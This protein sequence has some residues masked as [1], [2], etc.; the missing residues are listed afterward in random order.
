MKRKLTLLC[1]MALMLQM[2][3][4]FP[5]P[6]SAFA[7]AITVTGTFQYRQNF[8]PNTIGETVGERIK[9]GAESVIPNGAQG[10]TGTATQGGITG[11]LTF[12][13]GG[14]VPGGFVPAMP[15]RCHRGSTIASLTGPSWLLT[16]TNG[17]DTN[18]VFT[19]N[20]TDAPFVPLVQD[21]AISGNPL[22]P[23]FTWTIPNG[24]SP[25]TVL[26]GITDRSIPDPTSA[27]VYATVLTGNLTSFTVPAVFPGGGSLTPGHAYSFE[28]AMVVTR[29]HVAMPTWYE[30]SVFSISHT[31]LDFS[32]PLSA[33][34]VP[35]VYD[36]FD[37]GTTIDP[38]KWTSTGTP[39]LF[40]QHDGRLYFSSSTVSTSQVLVSNPISGD[41]RARV[42]FYD[43]TSSSTFL[44]RLCRKSIWR[45]SRYRAG[46]EPGNH[47]TGI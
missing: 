44:R 15:N 23:T 29:G 20:L 13:T 40:S 18:A 36:D 24:F 17:A 12:S 5:S 43:F 37:T 26:V 28:V 9:V 45:D 41:F 30:S 31:Y 47:H 46:F 32:I 39:G 22:T 10:T 11:P 21:L 38:S 33:G 7:A 34:P 27:P 1:V 6:P 4:F 42:D 19:P 2:V 16:F 35:V 14:A 3:P 8:G 25:D